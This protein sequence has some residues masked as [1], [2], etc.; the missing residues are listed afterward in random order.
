[1]SKSS[2][3]DKTVKLYI[4]NA[5]DPDYCE[6]EE[7]NYQSLIDGLK[8]AFHAEYGFMIDRV[9][10]QNAFAEWLQGLPSAINIDFQNYDILQLAV[11]WGSIPENATERAEDK[12]L[13]NWWRFI[14][15]KACQLFRGYSVPEQPII[16]K[17]Y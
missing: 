17:Q 5:I 16:I 3:L 6:A 7:G 2:E 9:G 1:M 12:I 4:L 15:A 13:E 11:K 14:A 10:E 8:K